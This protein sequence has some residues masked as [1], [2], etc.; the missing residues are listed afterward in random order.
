MLKI[1]RLVRFT[2]FL[3]VVAGIVTLLILGVSRL[4]SGPRGALSEG[5]ISLVKPEEAVQ[6]FGDNYVASD[7]VR[8]S[9]YNK[10][11][12]MA[13]SFSPDALEKRFHSS[14]NLMVVWW[15]ANMSIL[16]GTGARK[17]DETLKG[18]ISLGRAGAKHVAVYIPGQEKEIVVYSAENGLQADAFPLNGKTLLDFGFYSDQDSIWLLLLDTGGVTPVTTLSTY[19]PGVSENGLYRFDQIVY[20]VVWGPNGLNV[21]GSRDVTVIGADGE[22]LPNPSP[23]VYGWQYLDSAETRDGVSIL[24]ALSSEAVSGKP[25]RL[26]L[27]TNGAVPSEKEIHL[28]GGCMAAFVTSKNVYG[29]APNAIHAVSLDGALT[30]DYALPETLSGITKV[31]AKLSGNRILVQAGQETRVL[32]LP[33]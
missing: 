23:I 5:Q 19:R 15:G 33:G 26:K 18:D 27:V 2:I 12:E 32:T 10:N 9:F 17:Y 28:P 20:R 14:N 25:S 3:L 8:L 13:W 4:L 29:I 11:N 6:R 31:I 7:G 16:D 24:F 30:Q 22:T 1:P 21:I